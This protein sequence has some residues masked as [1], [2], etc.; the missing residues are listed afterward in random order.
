MSKIQPRNIAVSI[1]LSI[2]TCGIYGWY[3]MIKLT[4]EV[5]ELSYEQN[6]TSGAMCLILTLV[7]CGIYGWYWM[8]KMG[9][10]CDRI[11]G[12]NG[13][14]GIIFLLLGLFQLSIISYCL[15]QDTIN[16]RVE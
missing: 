14:S 10:K 15:I 5:N 3:W 8:Y 11:K 2:I 13:N 6:A 9:E 1:I 4:D 12:T 16:K 7:T